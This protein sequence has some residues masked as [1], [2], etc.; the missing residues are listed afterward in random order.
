MCTMLGGGRWVAPVVLGTMLWW[1]APSLV[2]LM[3]LR[4]PSRKLE[5]LA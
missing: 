1:Q 3:F 5:E 2:S 4:F